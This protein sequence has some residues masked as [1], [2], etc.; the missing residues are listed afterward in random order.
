MKL[1]VKKV[2]GI[3]I[4][5]NIIA[6]IVKRVDSYPE[7]GMLTYVSNSTMSVGGCVP[8]TAISLAVIDSKIPIYVGGKVGNDEN[9]RFIISVLKKYGINC[10]RV[11]VSADVCTS[12]CDVMSEPRGDRTFFHC[13]GANALYSPE[14][15]VLN[16][17]KCDLLHIGYIH[18]LDEFDKYDTE[19][20][21]VMAR[22]LSEVQKQG[23]K[24]SIDVVSDSSAD[25]KAKIIPALKYCDYAIMNE[26]ECSKLTDLSPYDDQAINIANIHKTME[27][28]AD[29]GVKE[30]VIIHCKQAG[31]CL[32]VATRTFTIVPSL[33][34]PK[35]KIKG[36]VGAGDSFCAGCLY[37][38][39]NGFDDKR[40]LEFASAVAASNL[41][42]ENSID[43]ILPAKDI[44]KLA[45]KYG[46][47][48][49]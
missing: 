18:L 41:F 6:D 37:S 43:G 40:I 14:D 24:T 13:K 1:S 21:T 3:A 7:K 16:E 29:A 27:F 48:K 44:E 26:V 11:S 2:N 39:Y 42:A 15:I 10:D 12:F 32:D 35:G 34:I 9:G 36:S 23:I 45:E 30:K 22:F 4:F 20:G 46:R 49:L 8:N 5:G 31:F 33:N 47:I 17:I 25:Y 28:M 38:I 19:Y